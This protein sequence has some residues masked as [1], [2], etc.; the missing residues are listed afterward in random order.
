M[1]RVA[2]VY[3]NGEIGAHFGHADCIAV[4]EYDENDLDKCRKILLDTT[5][6]NGHNAMTEVLVDE[7]V[8]AVMAQTMGQEAISALLAKGIIPVAGYK[9]DADT[10]AY[11]LVT[12]QLPMEA[13]TDGG[14]S[15][16]CGGG[17]SGC[18]GSCGCGDNGCG[19]H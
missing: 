11:M 1:M 5:D 18:G 4:Y 9:G 10:A 17:C 14:C 19:C 7:H 16:G 8:E 2:I 12:G 6:V 3:D 15:G 13:S